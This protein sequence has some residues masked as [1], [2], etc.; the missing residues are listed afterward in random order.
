MRRLIEKGLMFGNL[1]AVH[2]PTLIERYNRAL[3]HLV[4]RRTALSDFHIDLSGHSPEIADELGDPLYLNPRGVNRQF[5]LLTPEQRHAPLLEERFSTSRGL[6]TRFIDENLAALF[7]LTAQDAVAG[8]LVN[9]VYDAQT[10]ARLLDLRRL[11]VEADTVSGTVA[12]AAHLSDLVER[13]Q[14][15]PRAW[16][17]DVLIGQMIGL[18]KETGDI[19][20]HPV[21]LDAVESDQEDFWTGMYGG[22]YLFRSPTASAVIHA[23][24]DPGALPVD[25]V[26]PMTDRLA[27][28]RYL[29]AQGLVEPIIE[30]RGMDAAR[31]LA[32]KM[33]MIVAHVAASAGEQ[34][35]HDP[36]QMRRLARRY[37]DR[38]PEAWHGLAKLWRWAAEGGTWPVISADD[39]AYFYTLRAAPG[40]T[41][42]QVNRLLAELCPLDVLQLFICHKQAF[43]DAYRGWSD[44]KRAFVAEYLEHAYLENKEAVRDALFGSLAPPAPEPA[45]PS[46]PWG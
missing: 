27:V 46:G 38:L 42:D 19:L 29:S 16:F 23:G 31:V 40:P 37:A 14:S 5:I 44:P 15:E 8:E 24:D 18:A 13:F 26:I 2:S 21:A 30:A 41:Q 6:L 10:P 4:G 39:E 32:G 36:R 22:L 1:V 43:Y 33:E 20:R 35:N 45:R 28:A 25:H 7:A 3:E 9:S 34:P 17:D 12:T 11:R